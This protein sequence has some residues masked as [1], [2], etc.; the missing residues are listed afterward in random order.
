[1]S[2]LNGKRKRLLQISALFLAACCMLLGGWFWFQAAQSSQSQ[3]QSASSNTLATPGGLAPRSSQTPTPTSKAKAVLQ[4]KAQS[5]TANSS[6]KSKS[7]VN[8]HSSST[9]EVKRLIIP[10]IGINAPVEN[11]GVL[12]D[13]TLEVPKYNPWD[14]AGWYKN[15]PLPGEVG[16][17]VIDGHLD[18]P[19]GSPAVFWN[20]RYLHAGDL[21]TVVDAQG[22][23]KKF[24]VDRVQTYTPSAAPLEEIFGN[25]SGRHL[26]LITCAGQWVPAQHQTTHRLVVYTTLVS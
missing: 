8:G 20:L 3:S 2:L 15:G 25:N 16:S 22:R 7:N 21:V 11:V 14:G 6:D 10:A 23:T 24:Q 4:K 26:N 12:S 19:G 13:G 1:M 9:G 17:A 5:A 18:R